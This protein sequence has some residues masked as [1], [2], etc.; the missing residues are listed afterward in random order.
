MIVEWYWLCSISFIDIIV[1]ESTK[2]SYIQGYVAQYCWYDFLMKLK[3]TMFPINGVMGAAILNCE[4]RVV[5][6]PLT[7]WPKISA[8]GVRVRVSADVV[9]KELGKYDFRG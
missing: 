2:T 7:L 5:E 1:H 8:S 4:L 3:Q 9:G 6:V